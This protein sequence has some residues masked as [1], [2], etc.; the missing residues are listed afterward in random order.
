MGGA[1]GVTEL[2]DSPF[3]SP[4]PGAIPRG[5]T[6]SGPWAAGAG[7]EELLPG[8]WVWNPAPKVQGAQV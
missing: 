6:V 3:F 4:K 7:R 2:G 8:P 5:T 1:A